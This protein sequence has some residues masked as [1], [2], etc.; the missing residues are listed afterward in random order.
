MMMT[1]QVAGMGSSASAWAISD[2]KRRSGCAPTV[3]GEIGALPGSRLRRITE[4]IEE[5]LDRDLPL[6]ELGA[7]VCMSPYHFARLFRRSTGVPPHRFVVGKRID[8]AIALLV[9]PEPPIAQIA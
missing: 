9:A 6:A 3:Q 8:R 2:E 1:T 7:V 5:H 4:Y